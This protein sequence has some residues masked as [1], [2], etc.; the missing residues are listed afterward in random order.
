MAKVEGK[1]LGK[2]TACI[3]PYPTTPFE[4]STLR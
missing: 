4:V 3:F 2:K 1:E